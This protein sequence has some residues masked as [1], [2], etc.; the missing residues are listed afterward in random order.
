MASNY[1]NFCGG[2]LINDRYILTA[3]HCASSTRPDRVR[4]V[5]GAND[6]NNRRNIKY[7]QVSK[8]KIHP[9]YNRAN[10]MN[11]I[12]LL[13]LS[14]PMKMTTTMKPICLPKEVMTGF[15]KGKTMTVAGWG[16]HKTYPMKRKSSELLEV[17]IPL[18]EKSRCKSLW[19][20][21]Q[22]EQFCAGEPGKDSCLND[23]G[24][25]VMYRKSGYNY[26]AGIVSYGDVHCGAGKLGVYTNVTHY[27][28]WI[29]ENTS[30]ANDCKYMP[31]KKI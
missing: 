20:N 15:D 11:D 23:S 12:A 13:K 21:I 25:P 28:D 29:V 9:K 4:V 7:R 17:E 10:H 5:L 27:L 24:G 30:D 1:D 6:L 3:A 31:M 2:S 26:I 18:I 19:D 14:E 22:E 8:F 16:V